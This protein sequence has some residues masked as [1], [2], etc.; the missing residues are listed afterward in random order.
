MTQ[1][2]S[3]PGIADSATIGS[4]WYALYS[5]YTWLRWRGGDWNGLRFRLWFFLLWLFWN[6]TR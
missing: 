4:S 1:S 5:I 2:R 6:T 3:A